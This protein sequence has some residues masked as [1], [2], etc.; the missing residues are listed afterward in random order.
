MHKTKAAILRILIITLIPAATALGFFLWLKMLIFTPPTTP[1]S[2]AL[3]EVAPDE[4]L[5]SIAS[6]M[7][8]QGLIRSQLA[9]QILGRIKNI[10][11]GIRTGEYAIGGSMSIAEALKI[12]SKGKIIERKVTIP[13]GSTL[14]QIVLAID[15]AGIN[16]ADAIRGELNKKEY[17]SLLYIPA[18]TLEGYLFPDTYYFAKLTT[19]EKIIN[20]MLKE[21]ISQWSQEFTDRAEELGYNRHEILTLASIIEKESGNLEEQP[22][23]SSVFHNRLR[24]KIKLQSD[25]TVIYGL[26]NFNGNITKEDLS[27]PHPYNT[28][29]IDGLPPTP[30]CNPGL[31]AIKAALYPAESKYLYFVSNNNGS[32]IFSETY[33]E[34]TQMVNKHQK[35]IDTS[36][37]SPVS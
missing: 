26:N 15:Q 11:K 14:E 24:A 30:I 16:K 22:I 29:V 20:Q 12:L 4:S 28:Y 34:H 33:E 17:R 5:K 18:D 13:E 7:K 23:V 31:S 27:T 19:P 2:T 9:L 6:R 10:D 3:F 32:H 1:V 35:N 36:E 8:Q 21:S 37:V 25:P